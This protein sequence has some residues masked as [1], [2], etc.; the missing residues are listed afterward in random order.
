MKMYQQL[1]SL[2]DAMNRCHD[3][4]NIE[5]FHRHRERITNL[6]REYSPSGSGIDNGVSINT[7][8]CTGEKLVFETGFHHMNENGMYD[9]WT[10]HRVTVTPSFATGFNLKISG[11]DRNGIK[12]YLH[13]VFASWL[14]MGESGVYE[15]IDDKHSIPL[16][17]VPKC[18]ADEI[19]SGA[20][21]S[22]KWTS[23]DG[24]SYWWE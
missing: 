6:M 15:Y 20:A 3:T 23:P 21:T 19:A 2:V 4:N 10:E 13:D 7:D 8:D 24:V 16:Y 17:H 22:D 12:N 5:W 1:A 11:R 14:S 18:V 9:G